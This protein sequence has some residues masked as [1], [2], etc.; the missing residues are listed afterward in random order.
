MSYIEVGH[1]NPGRVVIVG[2]GFAGFNAAL[3][4]SRLVGA[5]TEIVLVNSA[6]YFLYVPLMPQ[7]AGGLVEPRHICVSLSRTL[8]K[9]RVVL[10]TVDH[11]D[12]RQ[13]VVSWHSPTGETDHLNYDRLILTAGSVD[14]LLP[15]PGVANYATGSAPLPRRSTC[16]TTSP[17]SSSSPPTPPTAPSARRAVPLLSSARDTPAPKS[18]RKANC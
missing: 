2:A 11:V 16:A 17:A 8:R 18:R 3:E 4:L 10:G 5:S 6:D 15:I 13:K 1:E 12:P 14:K 9:V 7:V